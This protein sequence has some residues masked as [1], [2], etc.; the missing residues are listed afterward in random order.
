MCRPEIIYGSHAASPMR[1][2]CHTVHGVGQRI[3]GDEQAIERFR[4][5]SVK[6]R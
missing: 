2:L 6:K 4:K 3:E 5:L 1:D